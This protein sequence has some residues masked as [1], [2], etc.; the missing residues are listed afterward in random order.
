MILRASSE[1]I[2]DLQTFAEQD[3]ISESLRYQSRMLAHAVA[4]LSR[5]QDAHI[6]LKALLDQLEAL[7][8][9]GRSPAEH[10]N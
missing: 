9:Q 2:H 10:A 4:T 8:R 1:I 6:H 7:G 3:G 5:A